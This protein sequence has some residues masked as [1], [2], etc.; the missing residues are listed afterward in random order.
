MVSRIASKVVERPAGLQDVPHGDESSF[1]SP[2]PVRLLPGIG[3][4][5]EG[6]FRD[7]N[8]HIIR[9][10]AVMGTE[11]L[12]L[13]FGRLGLVLRQRALGI[14]RTP[15]NPLRTVPALEHEK[16]LPDDS[17]DYERLKR[18]LSDL[19]DRAGEQLRERNQRSGQ[20]ALRVRYADYQEEGNTFRIAP[21]LQSS[22][23]LYARSLAV[24]DLILKRR[25]RVR[26]M[27][28]RLTDLSFGSVQLEL[29]ADPMPERQSRLESAMD[30]LRHRYGK[31]VVSRQYPVSSTPG[32]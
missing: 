24:L 32:F 12:I 3:V 9:D 2:L 21:P 7:L 4:Q 14:D 6:Q 17:N 22:A 23:I 5:T 27:H 13:A 28:L 15:V 19:C 31:A 11:H 1:L 10:I 16:I 8:I 26:S 29:F 20:V 18:V 25:T 30:A